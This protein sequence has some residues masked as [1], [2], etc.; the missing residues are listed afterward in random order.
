M[1]K[2]FQKFISRGN[3]VDL[4]VA[5]IVGA[6]FSTIVNSFITDIVTPMLLQ[7]VMNSLDITELEKVAWHGIK[8]GKFIAA[9]INFFVTAF[10]VFLMVR[11]MNKVKELKDKIDSEEK[12]EEAKVSLTMDQKLLEEIRDLLKAQQSQKN[13]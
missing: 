11:G 12:K 6:A 1:F 4:A 13:Q 5:V 10:I 9:I 7:P 8:Y 3:V 2:E